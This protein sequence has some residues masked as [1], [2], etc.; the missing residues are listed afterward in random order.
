MAA[1]A[2]L[3]GTFG[4]VLGT[5]AFPNYNH[6][7]HQL[8]TTQTPAPL[9]PGVIIKTQES[10]RWWLVSGMVGLGGGWWLLR[11]NKPLTKKQFKKAYTSFRVLFAKSIRLWVNCMNP[12]LNVLG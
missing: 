6:L 10:K 7:F 5:L 9:V 2:L 1:R 12:F 8:Q 11:H 4:G 3:S